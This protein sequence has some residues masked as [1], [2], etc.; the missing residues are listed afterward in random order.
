MSTKVWLLYMCAVIVQSFCVIL[1]VTVDDSQMLQYVCNKTAA[2][3]FSNLV[4][5]IGNHVIEMDECLLS[6]AQ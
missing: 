6:Q 3:F 4:W 2:P 1:V 5:F